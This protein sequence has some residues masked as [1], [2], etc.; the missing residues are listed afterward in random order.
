MNRALRADDDLV[1]LHNLGI[2]AAGLGVVAMGSAAAISLVVYPASSALSPTYDVE[3]EYSGTAALILDPRT[4]TQMRNVPVRGTHRI[5]VEQVS[6]DR[7]LVR[8][9]Q[10]AVAGEAHLPVLSRLWSVDRHTLDGAMT[11]STDPQGTVVPK[12]LTFGWPHDAS[13]RDYQ[14][15]IADIGAS[16]Q[17]RCVRREQHGGIAT[18]VFTTEVRDH[19]IADSARATLPAT[20][21]VAV[22]ERSTAGMPVQQAQLRMA[23]DAGIVSDPVRL[24]YSYKAEIT[25]WVEPRSGRVVDEE[26]H[27]VRTVYAVTAATLAPLTTIQDTTVRDT[28]QTV[29]AAVAGAKAEATRTRPYGPAAQLALAGSG[30]VL[31]LVG[32]VGYVVA[33]RRRQPAPQPWEEADATHAGSHSAV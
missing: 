24:S 33:R 1:R 15:W 21:P 20:V 3:R 29:A 11:A 17:A 14:V 9:T 12:G 18:E 26:R 25:T 8:D 32:L 7:A 6:G 5:R 19:P 31:L 13:C 10:D 28:P 30:A 27:E 22:L 23:V 2:A 16:A 4:F